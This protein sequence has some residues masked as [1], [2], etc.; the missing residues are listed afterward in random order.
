LIPHT[1]VYSKQGELKN[2]ILLI[3]APNSNNYKVF[4]LLLW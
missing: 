3:L 1:F 4:W 2:H